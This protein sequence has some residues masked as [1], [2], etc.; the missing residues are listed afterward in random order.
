MRNLTMMFMAAVVLSA[1][2]DKGAERGTCIETDIG[3][4]QCAVNQLRSRCDGNPHQ[5]F[6][7]EPTGVGIDHCKTAGYSKLMSF[8]YKPDGTEHRLTLN[9]DGTF[10]NDAA[11]RDFE[12]A[13]EGNYQLTYVKR[14]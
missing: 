3:L 9:D 8:A 12:K 13:V 6:V 2:G 4:D 7:G 5:F 14:R 10:Y 1:C 11:Y